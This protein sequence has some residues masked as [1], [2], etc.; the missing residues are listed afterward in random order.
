MLSSHYWRVAF[1]KFTD[2][3]GREKQNTPVEAGVFA[4]D[5]LL[6]NYSLRELGSDRFFGDFL[7]RKA[8]ISCPEGGTAAAPL[9]TIC[10]AVRL[11]L[12]SFS[13]APLSWRSVDPS[14]EIP[15]NKPRERE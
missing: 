6:Q 10:S 3:T 14:S 4:N 11:S 5:M 13:F 8:I 9:R 15:A 12:Q 1:R 7:F 2:A